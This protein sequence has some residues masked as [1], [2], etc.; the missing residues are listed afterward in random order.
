MGLFVKPIQAEFHWDRATI[1]GAKGMSSV[2]AA[3]ALVAVGWMVDRWGVRRVVLPAITVF[4]LTVALM[5]MTPSLGYFSGLLLLLGVAGAGH[6]P[7]GYVKS[8]S[9]FFDDRRGLAIGLTLAGTGVG[10]TIVSQYVDWAIGEFGWRGG[11]LALGGLIWIVAL[12]AVFFLVRD[13][14]SGTVRRGTA[15]LPDQR[16][17]TELPGHS[18]R[19]ALGNRSFWTIAV[20]IIVIASSVNGILFHLV[21]MLVDRGMAPSAAARIFIVFGLATI[22]GRFVVGWSF[23]KWFAPYVIA[24]ALLLAAAG[25]LMM[26]ADGLV[27]LG[28]A[29]LGVTV[30]AELDMIGYLSSRYFGLRRQGQITGV[31]FSL[32]A[33]GLATGEYGYG[34][35]QTRS[36]SYDAAIVTA[37]VLLTSAAALVLTLGRYNYAPAHQS[38]R[39]TQRA[40]TA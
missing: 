19:E 34:V 27:L 12:P 40:K 7:L 31:F 13:P 6:S 35:I 3:I 22:G 14:A 21:P 28:A 30:G 25:L 4:G 1:S 16:G 10:N 32:I 8:V 24:P 23:D 36:G 29:C 11:F 17:A 26:R 39:P 2:L 15:G 5:S 18:L 33:L 9:A 20:L 37:I 38:Q